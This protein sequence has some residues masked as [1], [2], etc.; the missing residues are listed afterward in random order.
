MQSFLWAIG[1]LLILVPIIYFL[2]LG[3]TL[4]GKWLVIIIS[5]I[6][7][8][9]GLLAKTIFPLW[10][11]ILMLLLLMGIVVYFIEKKLGTVL[12]LES[13]NPE[14]KKENNPLEEQMGDW[15]ISEKLVEQFSSKEEVEVPPENDQGNYKDDSFI[16]PISEPSLPVAITSLEK[17][18]DQLD[19]WDEDIS[20]IQDRNQLLED[21]DDF[22]EEVDITSQEEMYVAEFE[23]LMNQPLDM[24][25]NESEFENNQTD[26]NNETLSEYF[27]SL[28]EENNLDK[29]ELAANE[30]EQVFIDLNQE[31][32]EI[33]VIVPDSEQD[34]D[35]ELEEADEQLADKIFDLNGSAEPNFIKSTVEQ[36]DYF[37]EL[38]AE[39]SSEIESQLE[40]EE[41]LLEE[42]LGDKP[43]SFESL[44]DGGDKGE[45][46]NHPDI[47]EETYL[48]DFESEAEEAEMEE[49]SELGISVPKEQED[50]NK[51]IEQAVVHKEL[52]NTMVTQLELIRKRV[53]P[54]EYEQLIKEHMYERLP[55]HD[56]YTFASLL[57]SHYI[58][59]KKFNELEMLISSIRNKVKGYAI[60]EQELEYIYNHYCGKNR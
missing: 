34:S 16:E 18:N 51:K 27:N 19:E 60:L 55:V 49:I 56:Y 20:F 59:K 33:G 15:E 37:E 44:K 40:V 26:S 9:T 58:R 13:P 53:D 47:N 17:E 41:Q 32:L 30:L 12:F 11:T 29:E 6:L 3:I 43:N 2:P 5:F 50:I 36:E 35:G 21:K 54:Q 22:M 46:L 48:L 31:S 14:T 38:T 45:D 24:V 23:E 42:L 7:G 8:L 4:R 10:K 1:S 25:T 28:V 52:L 57:I 39:M